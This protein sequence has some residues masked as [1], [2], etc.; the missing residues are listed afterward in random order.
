[1]RWQSRRC[2][3]I[4]II[5]VVAVLS[6]NV[7]GGQAERE[8]K[9]PGQLRKLISKTQDR[10][11]LTVDA[12]SDWGPILG[13]LATTEQIAPEPETIRQAPGGRYISYYLKIIKIEESSK[14]VRL[15]LLQ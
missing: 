8:H 9:C 3:N 10:L 1:M 11:V 7:Q 2:T 13:R 6:S 5:I 12:W 4:K 15:L 14:K